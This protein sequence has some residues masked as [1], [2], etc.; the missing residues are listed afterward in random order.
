MKSIKEWKAAFSAAIHKEYDP[1]TG[2]F[3]VSLDHMLEL[4]S[5]F[6][7]ANEENKELCKT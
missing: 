4:I 5:K 6:E 2:D 1:N 3:F 7:V